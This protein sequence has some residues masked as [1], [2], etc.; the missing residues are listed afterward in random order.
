MHCRE[1]DHGFDVLV[2]HK[3]QVCL[4]LWGS[5]SWHVAVFT[6]QAMLR[7]L[8]RH[9]CPGVCRLQRLKVTKYSLCCSVEC[10]RGTETSIFK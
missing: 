3:L 1:A 9:K 7:S 8:M 2:N 4:Q 6:S 10:I 5:N